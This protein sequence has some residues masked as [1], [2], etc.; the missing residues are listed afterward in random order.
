MALTMCVI[1]LFV[2]PFVLYVLIF[3]S[4]SGEESFFKFLGLFILAHIAVLL[5][6]FLFFFVVYLVSC[7]IC[8]CFGIY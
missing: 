1:A 5:F 2:L 3:Y 4:I 8:F 6:C 7:L